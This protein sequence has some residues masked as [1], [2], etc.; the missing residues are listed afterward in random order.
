MT[1]YFF[2]LMTG[3]ML[4]AAGCRQIDVYEKMADIPKHE[5]MRNY[6]AI[7]ELDVKDSAWYNIII[8]MRHTEKF[9]YTHLP[10]LLEIKDTAKASKLIASLR[11]S[12]PLI[13]STGSWAGDNMK[14]LYYHRVAINQ[15]ILLKQGRYRFALQHELKDNPLSYILNA[16]VAIQKNNAAQQ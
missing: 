8:V 6:K 14:D 7:V 9:K 13:N 4:A 15:P 2:A 11:F 3:I 12:I 16:G 10:A 1:R 5:W